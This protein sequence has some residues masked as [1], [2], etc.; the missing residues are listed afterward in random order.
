MWES[1]AG[2]RFRD[3]MIDGGKSILVET[4]V[5]QEYTLQALDA[6][7]GTLRWQIALGML[8]CDDPGPCSPQIA[9]S[10]SHLYVLSRKRPY[11]LQVFDTHT[12]KPLGKHPIAVPVNEGLD[13]SVLSDDALYVRTSVHEGAPYSSGSSTS[14]THYFVYA[15]GLANGATNW[16]YDIGSLI[17]VQVPITPMLLAA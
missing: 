1:K 7:T 3:E 2:Y 17:D 16:K 9:A 11:T 15:I 5:Q 13:L 6:K 10:N 14:F 12:G 4:V 8:V